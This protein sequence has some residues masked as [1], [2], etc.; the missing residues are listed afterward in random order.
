M[1]IYKKYAETIYLA[2]LRDLLYVRILWCYGWILIIDFIYCSNGFKEKGIADHRHPRRLTFPQLFQWTQSQVAHHRCLPLLERP[3]WSS[4][5]LIQESA[6]Q[7]HRWVLEEGGNRAVSPG[8]SGVPRDPR[9][10][11][12]MQAEDLDR[13]AG[14]NNLYDKRAK[15]FWA[16]GACEEE[17]ALHLMIMF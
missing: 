1:I 4:P 7:R 15:Y 3:L 13:A 9:T 8:E 17:R 16:L 14:K 11:F 12:D 5:S 2:T 6:G 10:A